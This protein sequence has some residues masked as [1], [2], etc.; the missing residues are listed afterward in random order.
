MNKTFDEFKEYLSR[1]AR[2][3]HAVTLFHW[4]M[5]TIM[6]ECGFDLHADAL[7]YFS[8]EAFKLSTSKDL[9]NMLDELLKPE[10]FE[11]LDSDWQ[12]VVKKMNKDYEESARIPVDFYSAFVQ[13]QAESGRAWEQAKTADDYSIFAPHLQKMIDMT[14]EMVDYTHPGEEV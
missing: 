7:T 2:L 8:T 11:T 6:P 13:A 12:F 1:I 10:V 14:R 4:D 5:E 9:K 3:N